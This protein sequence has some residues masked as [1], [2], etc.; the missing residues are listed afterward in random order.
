[1]IKSRKIR[2]ADMLHVWGEK[3]AA[4]I[5]LMVISEEKKPFGRSRRR[6]ENNITIKI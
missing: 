6:W 5:V 4:Y 3:R 2:W 1:M